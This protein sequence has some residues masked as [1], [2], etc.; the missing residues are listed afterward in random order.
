MGQEWEFLRE[1]NL[2]RDLRALSLRRWILTDTEVHIITMFELLCSSL[3]DTIPL[4][5]LGV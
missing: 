2:S 3:G 1:Q 5:Q 4:C